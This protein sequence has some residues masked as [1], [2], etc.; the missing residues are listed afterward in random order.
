ML[1]ILIRVL[2][3]HH[4]AGFCNI[5][6]GFV[7]CGSCSFILKKLRQKKVSFLLL[8]F[9]LNAIEVFFPGFVISQSFVCAFD[10]LWLQA[11]FFVMIRSLIV[12]FLQADMFS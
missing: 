2:V 7:A 3:S 1:A 6:T 12:K 4:R 8:L 5:G 11:E 10:R 9:F